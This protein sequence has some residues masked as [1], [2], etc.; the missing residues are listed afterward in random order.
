[1]S[2]ELQ[3]W[4]DRFSTP[5]YHFGTEPN[6]FLKSREKFLKPGLKA[7]AIADGEGRNGVWL[8]EQGLDVHTIDFSPSGVAKARALAAK[9]G[10]TIRADHVDVHHWDWP[11]ATYDVVVAILIQFSPPTQRAKVFDGIKTAI[12]P[13]GL[14]LM[15]GYRPKQLEYGTGGPSQVE[16]LYTR[17]LLQDAFG[18]F[19]SLEIKEHD[20]VLN[21]GLRHVGMSAMIDLVGRK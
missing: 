15:Q 10:V 1:M 5:D 3:R 17:E 12:K 13:G 8:A 14:L 9:R 19:A 6:V 21:E 11:V 18:D 4:E 7:L 2:E 16:Q 20:S